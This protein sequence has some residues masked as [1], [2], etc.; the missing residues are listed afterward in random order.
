MSVNTCAI[1]GNLVRDP[2]LR[3]TQSGTS[4][5]SF[6]VAVGNGRDREADFIDCVAWKGTADFV[7]MWLHKG[8]KV[9]LSGRISTRS[10]TDRDGNKRKSTEIVVQQVEFAD[11][12]RDKADMPPRPVSEEPAQPV[13]QFAELEDDDSD[14]PF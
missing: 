1:V 5:A 8:S 14:L 10:W 3:H 4:V 9:A 6:T 12:P 11:S 13:N 7:S 2:E